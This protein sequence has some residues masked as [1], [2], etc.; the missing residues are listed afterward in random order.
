MFLREFLCVTFSSLDPLVNISKPEKGRIGQ[1]NQGRYF[2]S[3]ALFFILQPN[4]QYKMKPRP[5]ILSE[6]K[7]GFVKEVAI[8]LAI[9]PWGACEAHNYHMPY[10]TDIYEANYV[11]VESARKAYEQGSNLTVLPTIPFGV[12]TGQMDV[13]LDMNIYP[14][15]Q[16]AIL[17]DTI[18][19][20]QRAGV[21]KLLVLNSHGGNNFKT[22]LRELGPKYPNMLLTSCD[23][24]KAV[25]NNLYFEEPG[26]HAG[27]ME[28][29]FIMHVH[30]HLVDLS[31]AGDGAEK[32]IKVSGIKEGW[33]WAERRWLQVTQDTGIGNPKAAT[34]EKGKIYLEA[35]TDKIALL[36]KE[37]CEIDI[38]DL[39]E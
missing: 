18:N 13:R 22:I 12:N 29:A 21:D 24:F 16:Q 35:V 32:K 39:Y 19:V 15:T 31:L 20:L 25:D 11:A 28:T 30:G 17:D 4:Q 3:S 2:S 38:N 27:E 37:L 6:C 34:A 8:D 10:G 9:L 36:Y 14:S 1:E 23:W 26:D 33:A 5:Y 7:W